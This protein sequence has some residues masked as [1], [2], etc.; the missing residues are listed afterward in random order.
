MQAGSTDKAASG[1]CCVLHCY[2]YLCDAMC[3]G[4]A[5]GDSPPCPGTASSDDLMA[6]GSVGLGG[7][8]VAMVCDAPARA[9]FL[10]RKDIECWNTIQYTPVP[11]I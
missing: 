10:K 4:G 1:K 11:R 8:F 6:V 9:R 5:N 2:Q 7:V 3:D